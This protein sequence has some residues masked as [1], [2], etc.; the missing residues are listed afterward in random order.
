VHSIPSVMDFFDYSPAAAGMTYKSSVDG[1]GVT[2]DGA[3]DSVTAGRIDWETVDGAQGGL[4]IVH[5]TST[6]IPNFT[7]TSYYLDQRTPSGGSETQCTGDGAAYGSSGPWV[8]QSIPNTDPTR[9]AANRL[10]VT[11]HIYYESP[12]Q[13]DGSRRAAQ[14][15]NPLRFA[16]APW[17]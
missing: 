3:P 14:I 8:N 13:T 6:D 7:S 9:G 12:G 5:E 16:V 15:Q 17:G 1:R 11:R 2:I 10:E 4:S